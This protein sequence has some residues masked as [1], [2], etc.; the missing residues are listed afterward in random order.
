M[1]QN[2]LTAATLAAI[3][4][5]AAPGRI[6]RN[7][8]THDELMTFDAAVVDS[9]GAFLVGQLEQLDPTLHEPLYAFTWSRDVR[10]RPGISMADALSSWTLSSYAAAGG[11]GQGRKSWV[12]KNSTELVRPAL[13]IGKSQVALTE[14]AMEPAWT[15]YELE[16]AQRLGTPIDLQLYRAMQMKWN[17]DTDEQVYIGDTG[18]GITGLVNNSLVTNVGNAT[19]GGWATATA[20]QILDDV[21]ELLDSVWAASAYALMPGKLGLPP[22]QFSQLVSRK[23]SAQGNV[24]IM[25]FLLENNLAMTING[26]PLEIVPM[27]YLPG[28]GA[29]NTDRMIAYTDDIDRVRFSMVPLQRTAV[30]FQGIYQKAA[31]YGKLGGVEVVYPETIG[32]RDNI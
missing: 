19:T 31:Y 11:V 25:R 4:G 9:A 7:V 27:K 8:R 26:S 21:N 1:K 3:Y 22:T 30:Q 32:Y 29:G 16:A 18:L 24:S 15:V 6:I 14:W 12:G 20:D 5:A 2:A 17:M 13:D 10:V 28:A 23:V